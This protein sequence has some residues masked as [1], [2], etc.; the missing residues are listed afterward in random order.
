M[1]TKLT[2]NNWK[3]GSRFLTLLQVG[4]APSRRSAMCRCISSSLSTK[5]DDKKEYY[6]HLS[7]EIIAHA[8]KVRQPPE[9]YQKKRKLG[10]ALLAIIRKEFPKANLYLYGS[11]CN[12]FGSIESDVDFCVTVDPDSLQ[13]IPGSKLE[14]PDPLTNILN[15]HKGYIDR[16]QL[17]VIAGLL[18][19]HL[20]YK[21]ATFYAVLRARVPVINFRD[22][23][24]GCA[25][26]LSV[27]H[28]TCVRTAHL[29]RC[30]AEA[31]A[32]LVP[33]LLAIK[34]WAKKNNINKP[35]HGTFGGYALTLM[36]IHFL[37]CGCNPPILTSL[38]KD[39]PEYFSSDSDFYKMENGHLWD[40]IEPH[41]SNN[42]MSVGELFVNFFSYFN[43]RFSWTRHIASIHDICVKEK[44]PLSN[45][46]PN[47]LWIEDPLEFHNAA[48]PAHRTRSL[49]M[50]FQR[51]VDQLEKQV[52]FSTFV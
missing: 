23:K 35:R 5:V 44:L 9:L 43:Y 14:N 2:C 40:H 30:Y 22:H 50:E 17:H 33:L 46:A 15:Y 32:R 34:R 29:L 4:S 28:D 16:A 52:P 1:A 51:A 41:I 19:P 48:Y 6:A 25:F 21:G 24:T 49:Q 38:Q 13:A 12:G 3:A 36:C 42:D 45:E 20:H 26:D 27:N 39:H 31:D 47:R 18:R 10:A 8:K 37:Q 7:H 11:S